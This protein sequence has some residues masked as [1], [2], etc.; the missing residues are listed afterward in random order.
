[1]TG[2]QANPT[3]KSRANRSH[4]LCARRSIW[5]LLAAFSTT[6]GCKSATS[7]FGD[8]QLRNEN[9]RLLSEFRVQKDRADQLATRNQQLES[10]LGE[11]EKMVAQM[12]PGKPL[13]RL[14]SNSQRLRNSSS[15]SRS[16]DPKSL[17]NNSISTG[18]VELSNGQ[19]K[20]RGQSQSQ[21]P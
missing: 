5:I 9:A 10:R 3:A 4:M 11:S 20:V 16:L 13:G 21:N 19:W 7:F 12:L 18:E 15:G 6:I 1:V 2:S 17:P 8:Q 14:S